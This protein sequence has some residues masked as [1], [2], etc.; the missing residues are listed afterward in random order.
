MSNAPLAD[1]VLAQL[2]T[3]ARSQN[4][5]LDKPVEEGLL[6]RLYDLTKMGPTSAN[7]TPARF[8]FI[9]S[10]EAK[11]RLKPA[12]AEFNLEKTMTAPV[13]CVVANDSKFY[14]HMKMLFPHRDMTEM[15]RGN[16]K[17]SETS[18]MRSGSLQGGY[19]M[20]AAR[21]LGLDV[22][23][24]SGFDNAKVDAEFFPDGRWQSNF[25]V[26]LGYGDPSKVFGRLPRL[27]FDVACRI[28]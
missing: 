4:G 15:F 13:T 12:I 5:W 24:L 16:P 26:N 21:A 8:L 17:M 9:R 18:A 22:G 6:H 20:I 25:I 19:L 10:S 1:T 23:P 2:F 14:E 27:S 7:S 11:A 28:E 3:D